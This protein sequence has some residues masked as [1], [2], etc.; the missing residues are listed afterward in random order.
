MVGDFQDQGIP[1]YAHP[2][3]DR[4]ALGV[5]GGGRRHFSDRLPGRV[6]DFDSASF[7][8]TQRRFIGKLQSEVESFGAFG[9]AQLL[10]DLDAGRFR[11]DERVGRGL[12]FRVEEVHG[13]EGHGVVVITRRKF[14]S[15]SAFELNRLFSRAGKL[16]LG[17]RILRDERATGLFQREVD[18]F[19]AFPAEI[20]LHRDGGIEDRAFAFFAGD[21]GAVGAEGLF[22]FQGAEDACRIGVQRLDLQRKGFD[23]QVLSFACHE[24]GVGVGGGFALS[25]SFGAREPFGVF[26]LFAFDFGEFAGARSRDF[27][28][29]RRFFRALGRRDGEERHRH[30]D[31]EEKAERRQP[32]PTVLASNSNRRRQDEPDPLHRVPPSSPD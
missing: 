21:Q 10:E 5:G 9:R 16:Y 19:T 4:G 25:L 13:A 6:D 22:D 31:T 24:V 26:A 17:E 20:A 7:A 3:R 29:R 14:D 12:G 23:E 2:H 27:C 15:D 32:S 1:F 18:G 11:R 8:S 30:G 28:G